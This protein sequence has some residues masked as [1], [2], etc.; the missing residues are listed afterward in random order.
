MSAA[1]S[2][3]L[4]TM[5]LIECGPI[6]RGRRRLSGA[7]GRQ[8]LRRY[9]ARFRHD[10][11]ATAPPSRMEMIWCFP[12]GWILRAL[13]VVRCMAVTWAGAVDRT[14]G[15]FLAEGALFA[16]LLRWAFPSYPFW[17]EVTIPRSRRGRERA[18]QLAADCVPGPVRLAGHSAGG[19][20]GG[21]G[22]LCA[23]VMPRSGS[24]AP[25]QTA[26]EL[27]LR[28]MQKTSWPSLLRW[29]D[30]CS[31]WRKPGAAFLAPGDAV[32]GL[33]VANGRHERLC[34]RQALGLGAGCGSVGRGCEAEQASFR[35][36]D[37]LLRTRRIPLCQSAV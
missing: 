19:H 11:C 23:D 16:G 27:N 6:F 30:G 22:M 25:W 32:Y 36:I 7:V 5:S 28:E 4:G 24:V 13:V 15:R 21:R 8:I 33:G 31:A 37:G 9:L 14:Y 1:R 2:N 17:P 34:P 3:R 12:R 18:V 35:C 26:G 20:P 10:T 29:T